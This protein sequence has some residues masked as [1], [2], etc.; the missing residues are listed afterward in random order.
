MAPIIVTPD[1]ILYCGLQFVTFQHVQVP[2]KLSLE[3]FREHNVT[4]TLYLGDDVSVVHCHE[5]D[6]FMTLILPTSW[7]NEIYMVTTSRWSPAL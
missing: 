3:R 6:D 2:R 5:D 7:T 4:N 1:Q